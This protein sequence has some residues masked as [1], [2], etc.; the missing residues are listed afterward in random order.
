LLLT[1]EFAGGLGDGVKILQEAPIGTAST[2]AGWKGEGDLQGKLDLDIPL[3][4]GTEPKIVVDFQTDKA[5]LQL[6]EPPLDLSQLKGDFR[7]DSAKGL[8]GQNIT[9]Q[10]SIGRSP[11]RSSRMASRA[12]SAPALPPKARSR[13]SA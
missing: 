5:R 7:F 2:F 12:V 4:K 8:S 13:S 6:A 11:R 10:A 9:A 3:A 1:G